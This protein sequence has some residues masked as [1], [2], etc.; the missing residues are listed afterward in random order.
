[1]KKSLFSMAAA[2]VLLAA[3]CSAGPESELTAKMTNDGVTLATPLSPL[4][5][6]T[7]LAFVEPPWVKLYFYT[8]T[9]PRDCVDNKMVQRGD[10]EEVKLH[11]YSVSTEGNTAKIVIDAELVKDVPCLFEGNLLLLPADL[12]SGAKFTTPEESGTIPETASDDG[13]GLIFKETRQ[14]TFHTRCGELEINIVE[15]P[16]MRLDDRRRATIEGTPSFWLGTNIPLQ[17]GSPLRIVA[18]IKFTALPGLTI[19]EPRASTGKPAAATVEAEVTSAIPRIHPQLPTPVSMAPGAEKLATT[20]LNLNFSTIPDRLGRAAKRIFTEQLP[21]SFGKGGT[22]FTVLIA[23]KFPDLTDPEG[24]IL[25]VTH[26]DITVIAL[27]ERGAF[28]AMQTL[29]SLYRDGAFQTAAVHDAP[30]FKLRGIHSLVDDNSDVYL[31]G[32]IEDVLA[33][34]KMNYILLESE[35][36]KWDTSAGCHQ[37]WAASK[38]QLAKIIETANDNYIE[39]IPF[40]SSLGYCMWMFENGQNAEL[41]ENPAKPRQYNPSDPKVYEFMTRVLGEVDEVFGHQSRRLHVGHDE[42]CLWNADYP[43]PVRPENIEK[44]VKKIFFDDTMFYYDYAKKHG[45]TLMIWQDMLADRNESPE[46]GAGG[47][48]LNVSEL[49]K[50]LPKDIVMCVWRYSG[51]T[52]KFG[53]LDAM[54]AEGFPTIACSWFEEF[55]VENL[56][57]SAAKNGSL[58]LMSTTWNGFHGSRSALYDSFAQLAPYIRVGCRGWNPDDR[59]NRYDSAKVLGSMLQYRENRGVKSGKLLDLSGSVNIVFD[60]AVPALVNDSASAALSEIPIGVSDFGSGRFMVAGPDGKP[61]AVATRSMLTPRF[62][63][64]VAIPFAGVKASRLKFLHTQL[65]TPLKDFTEAAVY[66][67]KY[68]DDT[69]AEVPVIYGQGVAAMV[70]G[71]CTYRLNPARMAEFGGKRLWIMEWENPAKDK[72]IV[73]VTLK[74]SGAAPG[75]LLF[76]ISA[77]D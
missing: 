63:D 65:G 21:L 15:G 44:G 35:Y 8:G 71:A 5:L 30:Y 25:N 68:D 77:E 29:K 10:E 6:Q 57:K 12:L 27:S 59:A 37:E 22:P 52:K 64:E 28:Y 20:K 50:D 39:V 73:E 54:S 46:N 49:R 60:P 38:E 62:P 76:G 41:A 23:D 40:I 47:P 61:G 55:N 9:S 14:A 58:G 2:A 19:P 56:A 18:E 42:L 69:T 3:G 36:A 72:T 67:V 32:M 45:L 51:N 75:M 74:N 48:P 1:M 53:D 16:G 13:I 11:E 4:S 24:Y 66:V 31:K 17:Y 33:P 34:M 7:K 70:N 26:S 43:Y